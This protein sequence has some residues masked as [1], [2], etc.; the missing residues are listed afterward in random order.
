MSETTAA[1]PALAVPRRATMTQPLTQRADA[2]AAVAAKHSD[3]VDTAAR[4][5]NETFAAAREQR[6]LGMQVPVELGGEG[7]SVS[8]V[9]DVCYVL[10]QACAS[11]AMIFAMHQIMVR[12][13]VRHGGGSEWHRGLLRRIASEQLLLASSTTENQTGGDVRNSTCAVQ[14]TDGRIV[15]EKNATVMSYGAEADGVLTTARRAPDS[16]PSDQV[17]VALLKD[18]YE[19]EHIVDWDVLGMRG[20]C[21]T[22]FTLRGKGRAEQVVP[23]PYGTIHA[24][25]MAPVAHLTWSAVWTGAAAGAVGRAQKFVRNAARRGGQAPPGSA[26]LTRA[27]MSL[28]ALRGS[29]AAALHRYEVAAT[30]P[31]ALG[32]VDFQT[33]ISLLKVNSSEQAIATVL[34]AMQACGLSGYRNDGEFSICRS[35]RDVLSSSIMINNDRILASAANAL[36]LVGVPSLL[37]D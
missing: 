27:A 3:A 16:P 12:I 17:L 32:A 26:H 36:L 13:L 1:E 33:S 22:G 20:T 5:P 10:G 6:L 11:S 7:A 9:V 23:V 15:L 8:D 14:E 4:F 25:S 2:T 28:R 37:R 24:E 31:D 30:Q 18:D 35:L 19:L 29:V 21:S 34:A